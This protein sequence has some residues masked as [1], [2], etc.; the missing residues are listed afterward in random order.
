MMHFTVD[1]FPDSAGWSKESDYVYTAC[2][3]LPGKL[4]SR[5]VTRHSQEG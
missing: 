4:G 5:R 1:S 2:T 3:Q